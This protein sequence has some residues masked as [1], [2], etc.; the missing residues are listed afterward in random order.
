[1]AITRKQE[2]GMV[3]ALATILLV[4][5]LTLGI[6]L[7]MTVWVQHRT[8]IRAEGK[9]I[10]LYYAE[11]GIEHVLAEQLKYTED[12]RSQ[13]G[14]TLLRD[15]P[16]AQGSYTVIIATAQKDEILLHA[17]G[18]FDSWSRDLWVTVKRNSDVSPDHIWFTKWRDQTI[19]NLL[20]E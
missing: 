15:Y 16:F 9:T 14:N 12:W 3:L 11:S 17:I 8:F 2:K 6:S 18:K 19:E 13:V 1:M 7:G 5:L 10:A 20:G 4:V